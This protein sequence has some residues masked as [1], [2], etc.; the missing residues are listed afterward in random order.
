MGAT[1]HGPRF[2][3]GLSGGNWNTIEQIIKDTITVDIT[4]YELK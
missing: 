1:L 3:S 2:G 4:I